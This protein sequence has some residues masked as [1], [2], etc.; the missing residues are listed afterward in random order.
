MDKYVKRAQQ[1]YGALVQQGGYMS[2]VAGVMLQEGLQNE[3]I[4]Q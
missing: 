2:V 3:A 4:K 1:V